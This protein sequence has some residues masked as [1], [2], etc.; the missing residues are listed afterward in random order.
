MSLALSVIKNTLYQFLGKFLSTILGLA[1]IALITRYL[2]QTGFGQYTT[3]ITFLQFFAVL[4]D[5]G[6]QMTSAQMLGRN[7]HRA[8]QI[9]NNI[10]SLRLI[11]ATTLLGGAVAI[12]WLMPYP[13]IIK[14][15]VAI[16]SLSF[17]LITLTSTVISIFQ[18]NLNM[19]AVASAEV[20]GRVA[21]LGGT[22]IAVSNNLGLL[23]IIAAV[24]VG[25]FVNFILLIIS[26]RQYLRL[27]FEVDLKVW[28]EIWDIS[29]PIAMTIALTL[30]Y[31]RADTIILSLVRPQAEVGI[32]GASYKVLDILVQFPYLFLGL[33][34]PL[35]SRFYTE[36]KKLFNLTI[37]K[38]FDF[39]MIATLPMIAGVIVLGEEI[40][41]FVAGSE[42]IISG[43]L[44]KILIVAVAAIYIAALF[45][46]AIVAANLQ[47]L[48][49]KY[50]LINAVI[51]IG[52][53]IALI[54]LYSY[55]AAA[56]LTVFTEM[57]ILISSYYIAHRYLHIRL[58]YRTTLKALVASIIMGLV[59]YALPPAN[60][61]ASVLAG[62]VIYAVTLYTLRGVTPASIRELLALRS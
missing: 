40:M 14:Q 57:F 52:L 22:W 15:G 49:I 59:L 62:A 50:Y 8:Q 45:G 29:W 7:E 44:L 33:L 20:W 28:R 3:I 56:I 36:N 1:S 35:L 53:Y 39:L 9:F 37:E 24:T 4:V 48:M 17:F 18:K 46:Y 16:A 12:A 21:L 43:V 31:F 5:F 10:F 54:P 38:V 34:L 11:S 42:F 26:A 2:G 6:L 32:Y 55:W 41:T 51:S 13:L 30:V 25:S 61:I 19:A 47:K 58:R 23:P 60:V 27:E